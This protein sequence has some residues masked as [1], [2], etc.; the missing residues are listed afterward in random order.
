MQ[1]GTTFENTRS[2]NLSAF[3][4][5]AWTMKTL[6]HW[7]WFENVQTQVTDYSVLRRRPME[8]VIRDN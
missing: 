3:R 8:I 1:A 4:A 2:K 6:N 7:Q 5:S